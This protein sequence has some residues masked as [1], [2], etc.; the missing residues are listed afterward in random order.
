M[1]RH[2]SKKL[3]ET[4]IFDNDSIKKVIRIPQFYTT[5]KKVLRDYVVPVASP[6]AKYCKYNLLIPYILNEGPISF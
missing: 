4:K 6:V 1:K 2:S 5:T 3:I